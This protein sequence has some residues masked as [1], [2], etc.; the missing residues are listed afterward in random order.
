MHTLS[1]IFG[2]SSD[3]LAHANAVD[4]QTPASSVYSTA[5]HSPTLEP[6]HSAAA[7]L[8]DPRNSAIFWVAAAAV[9]GLVL[10][11]GQVRFE[12]AASSRLGGR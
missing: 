2:V 12:A 5:E 4:S 8:T 3:D 6:P 7:A 9:L 11:T 1:D 10:V